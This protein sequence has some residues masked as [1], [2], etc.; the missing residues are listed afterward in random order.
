MDENFLSKA[1]AAA[2]K[3]KDKVADLKEN[4]WDDEKKDIIEEFKDGTSEK[5][6]SVLETL[7]NYNSLFKEA[8][9]EISSINASMALPPD[10]SITFKCLNEIPPSE[11]DNIFNKVQ[12]SKIATLL[13]KSLFRASDYSDTIKIGE[14]K[15]RSINIKMGLMPSVSVSYS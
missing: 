6:K 14:F 15:L 10:M 1:K 8:G 7:S 9:Y 4:L 5:F 11:R 3:M 12:D 2:S 13:L